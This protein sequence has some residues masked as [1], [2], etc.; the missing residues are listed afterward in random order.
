[1]PITELTSLIAGIKGTIDLAKGLKS[2]YDAHTITQSQTEILERLLNLQIDALALQ[3]KHSTLIN[4][5]DDLSKKLM[6]YERWSE[7]ESQY[8]LKE[9]TPGVFVR[10]YKTSNQSQ[11]PNHWLC[12][13]CWEDKKKAILQKHHTGAY[14]CQRCGGKVYSE[15]PRG[16]T[17]GSIPIIG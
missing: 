3:D 13:K 9:I 1:M 7:T 12:T 8:E 5:K 11:Q 17:I 2:A 10:S 14:E 6:E 15:S 16:G 4:E